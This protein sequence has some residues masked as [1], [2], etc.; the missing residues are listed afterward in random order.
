MRTKKKVYLEVKIFS[1]KTHY[2]LIG[3]IELTHRCSLNC[4]HCYC[5]GSEDEHRELTTDEW[6]KILDDIHKEGCFW[7]NLTG[8]EPLVRDD[9]LDIY[10]YAKSKG[11]LITILTNAHRFTREIIDYLVKSP[12][13]RIDITLNG[14]TKDTYESIT[15]VEGSFF[16]VMETIRILAEKGLPLML[17]TNCLKQNKHEIGRIKAFAEKI[18]GRLSENSCYF[19]YDSTIHPRLNRDRTPCIYRLSPEELLE[20]AQQDPD[21]W[22]EYQEWARKEFL[23]L[24]RDRS[25]LYMCDR[26]KKEFYINPY[27]RLKFCGLTERFS[28]DLRATPFKKGF[29]QVFPRLLKEHFKSDSK[30]QSCTLRPICGWCPAKA[31]LETGNEEAPVEY[32]CQLAKAEAQTKIVK[33]ITIKK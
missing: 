11:F 5:K 23:D 18:L 8:G 6:K 29:Y 33:E 25:F 31:F 20:V 24:Q 10:S 22:E 3:H 15:Q 9:F 4:I 32:Y 13:I 26:W 12:P 17:K 14:I 28:T 19:K 2:P 16:R 7:L 21:I 30:C 27:G 1:K